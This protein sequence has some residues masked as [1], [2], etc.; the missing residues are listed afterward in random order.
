MD[1][2]DAH[3]MLAVTIRRMTPADADEV[4]YVGQRLPDFFTEGGV[5]HL[6]RSV[7][8]R[9]GLVAV[10]GGQIVG[11]VTYEIQSPA[12][13]EILWMAVLP[14]YQRRGVGRALVEKLA[15]LARS[16]QLAGSKTPSGPIDLIQARTLAAT[17]DHAGYAAT[18]AFYQSVGFQLADVEQGHWAD[19]TDA[20]VYRRRI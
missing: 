19:G 8:D 15:D 18:R 10:Y 7:A 1:G 3:A 11:F 13:L 12:T 2:G 20:A 4:R 6:A 16:G 14:F 5:K 17:T 9:P